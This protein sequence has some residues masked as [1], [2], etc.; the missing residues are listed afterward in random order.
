MIKKQEVYHKV[1]SEL[2]K[3]WE[4]TTELFDLIQQLTCQMYDSSTK[5]SAVN[6]LRYQ[7]FCSKRGELESSQLP[8]CKD[9]LVMHTRQANYQAAIW[10]RCLDAQPDIPVRS[11]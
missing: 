3:T 6:E 9:C 11:G 5:T 7:L 1:F 4:I 2:G 8:P 10:N